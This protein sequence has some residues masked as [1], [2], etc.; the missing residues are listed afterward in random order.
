MIACFDCV[1]HDNA[2]CYG[3]LYSSSNGVLFRIHSLID[4]WP[5][6][7]FSTMNL[8]PLSK[9]FT[10][11]IPSD[12]TTRMGPHSHTLRQST[13]LRRTIPYGRAVFSRSSSRT[14]LFSSFLVCDPRAG[15]QHLASMA[16][17]LSVSRGS[18]ALVE[19]LEPTD[20]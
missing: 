11:Q 7:R 3:E 15:S 9:T 1:G 17:C 4:C 2:D 14:T 5:I 16:L 13:L 8:V 20:R 19:E 18:E 10:Y 6:M 12:Q